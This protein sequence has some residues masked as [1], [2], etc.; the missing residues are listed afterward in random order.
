LSRAAL[1]A[2]EASMVPIEAFQY[3]S[4]FSLKHRA[5]GIAQGKGESLLAILEARGLVPSDEERRRITECHDLEL[6]DR[7]IRL[8]ATA[9]S[10]D[11]VLG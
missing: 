3:R 8:A 11:A 2:L 1:K 6:L 7:W 5:A 4:E 9:A 10:V